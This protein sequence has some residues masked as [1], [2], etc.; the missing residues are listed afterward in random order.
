MEN[1][2]DNLFEYELCNLFVNLS[3]RLQDVRSLLNFTKKYIS[4]L[5]ELLLLKKAKS[6]DIRLRI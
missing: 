5:I 2:G 6:I 4:I 1:L 3:L